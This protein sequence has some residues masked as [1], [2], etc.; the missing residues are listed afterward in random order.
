MQGK[1]TRT[2][3]PS[4]PVVFQHI[5]KCA[6]ASVKRIFTKWFRNHLY[7]H[8]FNERTSTPPVKVD[9]ATAQEN[10]AAKGETIC[11]FGHFNRDRGFGYRDY[12]PQIDQI[13]TI[14]R[15]PFELHVSNYYYAKREI[16]HGKTI[17]PLARIIIEQNLGIEDYLRS[18]RSYLL[19]FFPE[20][21]NESNYRRVLREEFLFIGITERLGQT[22][23]SLAGLLDK[24]KCKIPRE[25]V[26][27]RDGGEDTFRFRELFEKE[28][29]FVME[30]Y[31]ECCL[32]FEERRKQSFVERIFGRGRLLD[33]DR[34][35]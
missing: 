20:G 5:P 13:L 16:A 14:I 18:H 22:I 15:D 28:N 35:S 34:Q 19:S 23:Y 7:P 33:R 8:Y 12:Y 6:G 25:N 24:P 11:L 29:P 1:Y 17:L 27:V 26:S 4:K 2:Y 10:A 30:I 31:R 9:L 32:I 21:M 3:D